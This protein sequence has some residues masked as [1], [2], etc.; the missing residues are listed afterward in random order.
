MKCEGNHVVLQN[1]MI[2]PQNRIPA[3]NPELLNREKLTKEEGGVVTDVPEL[4]LSCS[5]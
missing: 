3:L 4:F 5:R 2:F 1:R